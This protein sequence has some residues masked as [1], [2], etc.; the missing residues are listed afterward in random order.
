MNAINLKISSDEIAI[1]APNTPKDEMNRY[2]NPGCTILMWAR[3]A[4]RCG[5]Q[6]GTAAG[7]QVT[8]SEQNHERMDF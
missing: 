8:I 3:G 6:A 5:V 7:G 4:L 2:A 1:H